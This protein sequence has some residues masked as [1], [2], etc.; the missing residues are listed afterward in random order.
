MILNRH[1][2][3]PST[4]SIVH[5]I[6]Y[7]MLTMVDD[8]ISIRSLQI[9]IVFQESKRWPWQFFLWLV[10]LL[11]SNFSSISYSFQT[12]K[13]GY[14][15]ILLIKLHNEQSIYYM[16]YDD[17]KFRFPIE[18]K[19]YNGQRPLAICNRISI[20]TQWCLSLHL[21]HINSYLLVAYIA[22]D[23]ITEW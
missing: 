13:Q 21:N 17:L 9:R 1:N 18:Y 19:S 2:H 16:R 5:Q 7:S 10:F 3:P 20:S 6:W 12:R 8:S 15:Q 4:M 14:A 22:I 23:S 11:A